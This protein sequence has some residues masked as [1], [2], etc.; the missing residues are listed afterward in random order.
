[1]RPGRL[2]NAVLFRKSGSI[3]YKSALSIVLRHISGSVAR[4][5]RCKLHVARHCSAER[6]DGDLGI[7]QY[8]WAG[9]GS[10]ALMS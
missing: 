3:G 7:A 6:K 2:Q 8:C 4:W 10:C 1:M 5:P 9:L